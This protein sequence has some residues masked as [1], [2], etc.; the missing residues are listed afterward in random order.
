MVHV[1]GQCFELAERRLVD[2]TA[3]LGE[4]KGKGAAEQTSKRAAQLD[5]RFSDA[6]VDNMARC[7][8]GKC[9]VAD[10]PRVFCIKGCGVGVHAVKCLMMSKNR[11]GLGAFT[12]GE[13]RAKV[14]APNSCSE[15]P[16]LVREGHRNALF[17]LAS[18]ADGRGKNR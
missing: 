7:C 18:G 14:M 8:E 17:E 4:A 2:S 5:H 12:C 9:G 10:E 16:V 11:A 13:C 3:R 15:A 6:R 1:T